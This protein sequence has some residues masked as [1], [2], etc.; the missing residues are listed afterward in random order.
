M[1]A[2][3]IMKVAHGIRE[4]AAKRWGGKPGDYVLGI[5]LEMAWSAHKNAIKETTMRT[6]YLINKMDPDNTEIVRGRNWL[7][8]K[9]E[10]NGF[11]YGINLVTGRTE[12][13]FPDDIRFHELTE[14]A[15]RRVD[16]SRAAL[17]NMKPIDW[18]S[19]DPASILMD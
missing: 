4:A 5:A 18:D 7:V 16:E 3:V 11:V 14:S 2:Q 19:I 1:K 8:F 15:K 17:S 10:K 12:S 13:F 9:E 6:F